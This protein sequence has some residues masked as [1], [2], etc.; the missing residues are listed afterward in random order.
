MESPPPQ[1]MLFHSGAMMAAGSGQFLRCSQ[2]TFLTVPCFWGNI[3]YTHMVASPCLTQTSPS[4][5][6]D[7][8]LMIHTSFLQ[9]IAVS[10][11]KLAFLRS[12][13]LVN[14]CLTGNMEGMP[15][16]H[17]GITLKGHSDFITDSPSKNF[18]MRKVVAPSPLLKWSFVHGSISGYPALQTPLP[19]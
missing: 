17:L 15:P 19:Q 1:C 8:L 7:Q 10:P 9:K 6:E 11:R 14:D 2:V 13:A 16:S 12:L 5:L 18:L 4:F 3:L